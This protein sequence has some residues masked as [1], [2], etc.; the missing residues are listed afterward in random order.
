MYLLG[1]PSSSVTQS[2]VLL[3]QYLFLQDRFSS[4]LCPSTLKVY[5]AAIAAF[6]APVGVTSLGRDPLIT[7]FLRGLL[8]LRPATRTRV[9]AWDLAIVLEGLSRAPF[10]PLDSVSEKFLTFKT[11]FLLP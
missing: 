7:H 11:I 1:V 10:E 9:L 2:T 4:G 5:V 8:R 6:H 3:G